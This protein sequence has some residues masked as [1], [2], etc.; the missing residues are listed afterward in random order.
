MNVNI[1]KNVITQLEQNIDRVCQLVWFRDKK[2]NYLSLDTMLVQPN[3]FNYGCMAAWT[4]FL[5]PELT[6]QYLYELKDNNLTVVTC[7]HE[8]IAAKILGIDESLARELF[9]TYDKYH[10][11]KLLKAELGEYQ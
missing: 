11:I 9:Y 1:V 8:Y 3:R 4:M 10:A 6:E 7:E 2:G 5:Y